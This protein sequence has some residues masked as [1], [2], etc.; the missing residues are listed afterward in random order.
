MAGVTSTLRLNDM[1]TSVL[2]RI[3]RSMSTTIDSFEAVQRASGQAFD[4][5]SILAARREID[6]ANR[7]LDAM[8]DHYNRIGRQQEQFNRN[9]SHG[10]SAVDGLTSKL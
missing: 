5:Q 9:V 8:A 3:N 2:R 1:M 7:E 6:L 10:A 4:D